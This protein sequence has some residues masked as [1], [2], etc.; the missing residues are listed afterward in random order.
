MKTTTETT[1]AFRLASFERCN[2]TKKVEK[3]HPPENQTS[4]Q[5]RNPTAAIRSEIIPLGTKNNSAIFS[6]E[7]YRK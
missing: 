5:H 1:E 7:K 4:V 6:L 3:S 2:S